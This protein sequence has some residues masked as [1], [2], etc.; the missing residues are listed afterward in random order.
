M[1]VVRAGVVPGGRSVVYILIGLLVTTGITGLAVAMFGVNR[2]VAGVLVGIVG[3][4]AAG[5]ALFARDVTEL[6]EHA[7]YARTPFRSATVPW[8][9]VVAGRFTLD[10]HDRWALALDLTGD[11][12]DELVLLS[13]PPVSR[14]VSGAYDMRKREQ[15][16]EIREM[17]RAKRIPITVLPEIAGA[18]N[19]HWQIAPP[20]AR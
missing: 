8:D 15:V 2:V 4:I 5:V 14:P 3:G 6:T 16:S 18:L 7:I 20:T 10:E 1:A 13:I 17:L 9:R 12:A 11:T 19:Q